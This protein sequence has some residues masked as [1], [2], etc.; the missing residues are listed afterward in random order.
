MKANEEVKVPNLSPKKS[1]PKPRVTEPSPAN[2]DR[3][4]QVTTLGLA[5]CLDNYMYVIV[6]SKKETTELTNRGQEGDV[7]SKETPPSIAKKP[8]PKKTPPTSPRSSMSVKDTKDKR[9]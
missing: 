3:Y 7:V 2:N 1:L 6:C 8:K 5:V 4:V 9:K